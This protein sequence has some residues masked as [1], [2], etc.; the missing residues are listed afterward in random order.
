MQWK[1]KTLFR[2]CCQERG[3]QKGK[4][5]HAVA[6]M[7]MPTRIKIKGYATKLICY[8]T[9]GVYE[10]FENHKDTLP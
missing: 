6:I 7:M 10:W 3:K 4:H 2:G 8:H 9:T 5:V 1:W